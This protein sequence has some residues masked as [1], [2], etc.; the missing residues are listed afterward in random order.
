M[1][2]KGIIFIIV[3]VIVAVLVGTLVYTL[4]NE[5]NKNDVIEEGYTIYY[6]DKAKVSNANNLSLKEEDL[7]NV[8]VKASDFNDSELQNALVENVKVYALMDDS[9][10]SVSYDNCTN[11]VLYIPT[12]LYSTFTKLSAINTLTY[13]L[14][15]SESSDIELKVN[16]TLTDKLESNYGLD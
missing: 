6:L 15:A 14:K 13:N 7:I 4:I 8:F 10:K 5:D 2:K 12:K 9:G 3:F 11:I 16:D 1:S